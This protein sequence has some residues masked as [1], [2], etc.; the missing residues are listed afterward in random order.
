MNKI[1]LALYLIGI[2]ISSS[3]IAEETIR[4]ST[5]EYPPYLS[6]HLPYNGVG[7]RIIKEAFALEGIKVE[8]GFFPWKRSYKLAKTGEWDAS[9]TWGHNAERDKYFYFS[10]PLYPAV[11]VFFHLKSYK[12]DWNTLDDLKELSIGATTTYVY[13][14]KFLEAIEKQTLNIELISSDELNFRKLLKGRTDIFPLN[15]DVAF[16]LLASKFS[17]DERESITYHPRELYNIQAHLIFSKK[18]ERNIRMLS[19]FNKG[20]KKL[21]RSGSFSEYF[22]GIQRG[23]YAKE[24]NH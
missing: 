1:V 19:L 12:F 14:P 22:K 5:G 9:A 16:S 21:R 7:L 15:I 23:E 11:S 3:C 24:N 2:F 20:L 18:N 17:Q 4:I 8:Y 6:E 13:T 10:D